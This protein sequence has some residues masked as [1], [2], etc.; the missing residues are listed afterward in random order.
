M[1]DYSNRRAFAR[2]VVR[3]NGE[4]EGPNGHMVQVEIR[5]FCPGGMLLAFAPVPKGMACTPVKDSVISVRCLLPGRI[6]ANLQFRGK[7]VRVDSCSVGLSFIDPDL[8]A[9]QVL[10]DHVK[11]LREAEV[12]Q[13]HF[14]VVDTS[15]QPLR[16]TPA[17]LLQEC[18][19]RVLAAL[20]ELM[21]TYWV[22]LRDRWLNLAN[23]NR[24]LSQA[25]FTA[26]RSID[27]DALLLAQRF[28]NSMRDRLD[29]LSAENITATSKAKFSLEGLSLVEEDEFQSWLLVADVARNV[30]ADC[31]MSLTNFG[32]RLEKLLGRTLDKTD[33]PFWPDAFA[34]ALEDMLDSMALNPALLK[35]AFQVFQTVLTPAAEKM[36]Q[37]LNSCLADA[38]VLPELGFK[39]NKRESS[40]AAYV[41]PQADSSAALARQPAEA[42]IVAAV[43]GAE[44]G[45]HRSPKDVTPAAPAPAAAE[46]SVPP[47][48]SPQEW[49][50]IVQS[51]QELRSQVNEQ[52]RLLQHEAEVG[53]GAAASGAGSA[54]MAGLELVPPVTPA[55]TPDRQVAKAAAENVREYTAEEILSALS[56]L[57]FFGQS[58]SSHHLAA[59]VNALLLDSLSENE[60]A[61][62]AEMHVSLPGREAGILNL[63]GN[64]L[65]SVVQD[66]LVAQSVRPWL[67]RLSV[68]LLKLAIKDDTLFS[69]LQHPARQLLNTLAQFEFYGEGD[70]SQH[71]IRSRVNALVDGLVT[72]ENVS[73]ADMTKVV[74]ELNLV[75]RIQQQAFNENVQDVVRQC[76]AYEVRHA[77]HPAESIDASHL[78][79]R[80]QEWLHRLRRMAIGDA[81]L[82]DAV[83]N[84]HRLSLAWKARNGSRYAFVNAKG[85]LSKTL[86]PQELA[87]LL[88]NGSALV[89]DD[90][91]EPLLDRAQY[92]MLQKMHRD[93]LYETTHDPL[94]GL[95]NRREFERQLDVIYKAVHEGDASGVVAY[96]DI[97][98]LNVVNNAFGYEGG[99]RLLSELSAILQETV[100][101]QGVVGRLDSDEFGL[102]LHPATRVESLVIMT[103]IRE[104]VQ[105]YRFIAEGKSLAVSY[106]AGLVDVSTPLESCHEILQAAESSCRAA[107]D[108]GNFYVQVFSQANQQM[109][110]RALMSKWATRIDEALDKGEL[111]LRYQPIARILPSGCPVHHAEILLGVR[112]EDGVLDSPVDFILAA[113]QLRRMT[114]VDRWVVEKVFAWLATGKDRVASVQIYSINLSGPS[115]ND[116]S[117]ADFI[118]ERA[119]S[120]NVPMQSV[121]FEI[122]ET[123]GISSLSDASAFIRKL[124]QA[125]GC[126]F[127][128]DDFGSGMSSYAYLKNLPVDFLKIDGVFVKDLDKNPEDR[129]VVRSITEIGHFMGKQVIAEYVENEAILQILRGIGVEFAQGYAIGK[130]TALPGSAVA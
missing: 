108:K 124:R 42:P 57:K 121:C 81:V 22:V 116:D 5:D 87:E 76:E 29:R 127:S 35:P 92:S 24:D 21:S 63:T 25:C 110:E 129:A 43:F 56:R 8:N 100:G 126:S 78:S 68:P 10:Y 51:L 94:T 123:A 75:V 2:Q 67:E 65:D 88:D 26:M 111:E 128:L 130:P 85:Q 12:Q 30:E 33:N 13:R 125:T 11:Q 99:N 55:Q 113:E 98:Q 18:R 47:L 104:K 93:L 27:A 120:L 20:P 95:I 101:E 41:Q 118:I 48:P 50:R 105:T 102:L 117:F 54:A 91:S 23:G 52:G 59:E 74:Q 53:T 114:A 9:V 32:V 77:I 40:T 60:T 79:R 15:N 90:G 4:A 58:G 14:T 122:T 36:Y 31:R 39:L 83:T 89:M 107:R 16:G 19:Q 73:P 34:K 17:E 3:L 28:V 119:A 103:K 46:A 80:Q 61:A 37:S 82:F 109:T 86:G 38:G 45:L 97:S 62:S 66:K 1:T 7:V 72:A 6:A 96:I 64:L 106:S 49:Y 115:L 44:T 71:R 70:A 69:D 112:N 84:P